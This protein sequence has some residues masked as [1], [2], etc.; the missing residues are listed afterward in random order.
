MYKT[1]L[2]FFAVLIF[3]TS[4]N[5]Q[6]EEPEQLSIDYIVFGHFYGFCVGE[7]CIEMFKLTDEGLYENTSDTYPR[8]D[9]IDPG[10]WVKLDQEKYEQVKSLRNHIPQQLLSAND[11]VF[12]A[13]D[14]ADGGGIYFAIVENDEAKFW[15]FDQ[16]DENI[17]EYLRPFKEQINTSIFMIN[18]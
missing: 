6:D 8:W 5:K 14:A 12:G 15:L 16:M 3:S 9:R 10:K 11:T 13:P 4:C 17:P 2:L 7:A 1:L 18:D